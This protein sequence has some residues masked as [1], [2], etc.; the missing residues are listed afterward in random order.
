MNFT[1][2]S[3]KIREKCPEVVK[4][5]CKPVQA[6]EEPS[7]L[8][9][10]TKFGG[11]EPFRS[12]NFSWPKCLECK[13]QKTFICQI[14]IEKIPEKIK[15]HIKRNDGLFQCFFCVE[16]MP[17]DGCVDDIC[18]VPSCELV[19]NLQSLVSRS[20]FHNNLTT[21]ELPEALKS[22][23]LIHNEV[24]QQWDWEGFEETK[25]EK[26]VELKREIPRCEEIMDGGEHIILVQTGVT[27]DELIDMEDEDVS[28]GQDGEED[29][30]FQFPSSGIKLGGYIRWCQGVEYPDCPDCKVKMTITFLQMEEDRIFPFSWGDAGTAHVTLCPE[31]GRPGLGW[32]CC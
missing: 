20:I 12:K 7:A 15:L 23:V 16:C 21:K 18:F 5:A 6:V 29:T 1:Q 14:N 17:F 8:P 27:N 25:I 9:T 31:C 32:A 28:W 19:P 22:S 10:G 26:W 11:A 30:P 2:L 4:T 24:F 3:Q 13:K